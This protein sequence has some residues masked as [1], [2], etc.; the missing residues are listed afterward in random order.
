MCSNIAGLR[1]NFGELKYVIKKRKPS[2]ILLNETHVTIDC[3]TNDLKLN[4]YNFIKCDS[5]SKHTG[6]VCAFIDKKIKTNNVKTFNDQVAW[7]ISF[8]I[9]VNK[10]PITFAGIYL[11]AKSEHKSLVLDSFEKWYEENLYDKCAVI[12]G[13]F[14]IDLLST[15]TYSRRLTQFCDDN[16]L[17]CLLNSATRI[18]EYSATL[19]DLCLTNLAPNRINSQINFDDQISDH[20]II[21]SVISGNCDNYAPKLKKINIW[22]HYDVQ[23]LWH[24]LENS[25][26]SWQ[27]VNMGDVDTKMNW[28]IKILS[29][30]T[31]Q[32][33]CIKTIK[34]ND[35]FFDNELE[36]MRMEKNSLYKIA[37]YSNDD[38][39]DSNELWL[40]YRLYRNTYKDVICQKKYEC[41]QRK[42]NRVKGNM[43]STW[44]VLNSILNNESDEVTSIKVNGI[45]IENDLDIANE[46]NKYFVDSIVDLNRG[47]PSHQ[48]EN[49]IF[50]SNNPTFNFRGVS[51]SEIKTCLK[52]LKNNTDEFFIKPSVLLDAMFVIGYQ[53]ADIINHSFNSGIFPDILKTSTIIPIQKKCGSIDIANHR[54]INML[55]CAE[56]LIESLAYNQLIAYVTSN[57]LLGSHQSGFRRMHSC[58]SAI[59]DVLYDWRGAQNNSKII[60][61]VFL[62]FQRAFETIEPALAINKLQ[63][64]GVRGNSLKW[65]QSYLSNRKQRVKIGE[66]FSQEC[67]N[68]LGVPQG[69]IL[70]PLIF[71]L[72]INN[73]INCLNHCTA[74]M[75]ADDTLIYIIADS[76]DDA[77]RKINEDLNTLFIKLCQN[78]LKLNLD[79]TKVMVITNKKIDIRNIHIEI[80]GSKLEIESEI[81][82]LGVVIDDK[83]KFDRNVSQKCSKIGQK[84]NVL[85]RLRNELNQDQK[86]YIYKTIIQPHIMYCPSILYL[87]NDT[88]INRL[89]VLQNK[90]MR[91]IL[92]MDR[93]TNSTVML[94]SLNLMS[95]KQIIIYRTLLF[96]FNII[97]GLAPQYLT[98]KIKYNVNDH[99]LLRNQNSILLTNASKSC[100]QNALFYKGIKLFNTLPLEI[101]NEESKTKFQKILQIYIF[102]NI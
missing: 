6:G 35:D 84:L 69:S 9:V 54:P 59:N 79:K 17:S 99:R 51:I 98:D 75:F 34:V 101:K 85:N 32:F 39:N 16:G 30:A 27:F 55:P 61:A 2:V 15:T 7:Y 71:I 19:I 48:Y 37:Q 81:K 8:E 36:I 52:E 14:N 102:E 100:S 5:H 73:I 90:C 23:Q 65:F 45:E 63:K 41:N 22:L 53:V 49:E 92:K 4:G 28:L 31:N 60:I 62:D 66:S 47:I 46:F 26:Y 70:G 97:H 1:N 68:N 87:S 20:A 57:N 33:K 40:E 13:D 83:L 12:M 82:Y 76:L 77:V 58:E 24:S 67:N 72:Y 21:E 11:S 10:S 56:R 38:N 44:K 74:K 29:M 86:L 25:I 3:D 42:L 89:Q 18:T 91:Q 94:K 96:I 93:F 50:L 88:D 43:K 78:K 64:Y 80:N 95:V